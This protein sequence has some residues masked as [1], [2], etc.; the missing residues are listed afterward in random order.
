MSRTATVPNATLVNEVL[1]LLEQLQ[2]QKVKKSQHYPKLKGALRPR[3]KPFDIFATYNFLAGSTIGDW[4]ASV[5]LAAYVA[6]KR[7]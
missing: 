7:R 6:N 2:A 3:Y 4:E 5:K 1:S